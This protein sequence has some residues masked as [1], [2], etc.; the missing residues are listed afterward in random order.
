MPNERSASRK[1][2]E[3]TN[4]S[5]IKERNFT[6]CTSALLKRPHPQEERVFVAAGMNFKSSA[7]FLTEGY[8][9]YSVLG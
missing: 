9:N 2:A 3:V 4:D 8:R 5:G 6:A 7:M 1:P